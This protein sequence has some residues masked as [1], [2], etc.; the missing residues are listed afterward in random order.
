MADKSRDNVLLAIMQRVELFRKS[1]MSHALLYMTKVHAGLPSTVLKVSQG[2]SEETKRLWLEHFSSPALSPDDIALKHATFISWMSIVSRMVTAWSHTEHDSSG[3]KLF[4]HLLTE[5]LAHAKSFTEAAAPVADENRDNDAAYLKELRSAKERHNNMVQMYIS[6]RD[7]VSDLMKA[8]ETSDHKSFLQYITVS[9][10]LY[11]IDSLR[12]E[13]NRNR[14]TKSSADMARC[15]AT[16]MTRL[17]TYRQRMEDALSF[18]VTNSFG[19]KKT[20]RFRLHPVLDHLFDLQTYRALRSDI[21]E[22]INA[23][24][25]NKQLRMGL[26]KKYFERQAL[27]EVHQRMLE[28]HEDVEA[29]QLLIRRSKSAEK[30]MV[31][32]EILDRIGNMEWECTRTWQE[33]FHNFETARAYDDQDGVKPALGPMAGSVRPLD[34][35]WLTSE[36]PRPLGQMVGGGLTAARDIAVVDM[37]GSMPQLAVAQIHQ[38]IIGWQRL[39]RKVLDILRGGILEIVTLGVPHMGTVGLFIQDAVVPRLRNILKVL[40]DNIVSKYMTQSIMPGEDVTLGREERSRK[41]RLMNNA[42]I[43]PTDIVSYKVSET[44]VSLMYVLK[45]LRLIL[46]V[47]ALFAAQK[48]FTETYVAATAGGDRSNPPKMGSLLYTFL[49]ID[50][51]FQLFVLLILVLLSYLNKRQDNTYIIDDEYIMTFLVEYFVTTVTLATL[52][53]VFA[54]LMR[55]KRYFEYATQGIGVIRSYRD[56]MIGTCA[57]VQ[58]IPFFMLF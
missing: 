11:F 55:S 43:S 46:Q 27:I 40:D 31:Q 8:Q 28:M 56:I 49:A 51:T 37:S 57:V 33:E 3:S 29:I 39:V 54:S 1:N 38:D 32:D 26:L 22:F 36:V 42:T 20:E 41:T 58:C 10:L 30:Q 19:M 5:M 12:E 17:R 2:I 47:V 7:R 48:I 24:A 21:M 16:E 25:E 18:E 34:T 35:T 9:G 53:F 6:W 15:R 14:C 13:T 44:S 4:P 50:A 23:T 45:G 52:G